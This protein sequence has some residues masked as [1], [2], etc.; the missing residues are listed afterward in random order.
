MSNYYSGNEDNRKDVNNFINNASDDE[1]EEF[2]LVFWVNIEGTDAENPVTKY[3][4]Q[5]ETK[6][7]N[8]YSSD[9]YKNYRHYHNQLKITDAQGNTLPFLLEN[10]IN[11]DNNFLITD[12]CKSDES[13]ICIKDS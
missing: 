8:H 4:I 11:T 10:I 6:N 1:K 9:F 2:F 13:D 7:G 3:R 12:I 5:L